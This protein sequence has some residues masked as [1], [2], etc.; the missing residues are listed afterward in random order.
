MSISD[1]TLELYR[2]GE[3]S[4]LERAAVEAELTSEDRRRLA[5][6][7]TSDGEIL[8]LY[9]PRVVAI[10]I[11]RKRRENMRK[12]VAPALGGLT[13]V[14]AALAV[15]V[16]VGQLPQTEVPSTDV[17]RIL[18]QDV[19]GVRTKSQPG[20]TI[21]HNAADD[22]VSILPES[23]PV[24]EGDV[25]QLALNPG[26]DTRAVA[27]SI[28]GSGV[29]TLH[30][31]HNSMQAGAVDPGQNNVLD[32]A[33]RLDDAPDFER[34]F[35]VTGSDDFGVQEV[36]LAAKVLAQEPGSALDGQLALPESLHVYEHLLIKVS[37]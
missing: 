3:L 5:D 37:Q 15:F 8:A 4:A 22:E 10:D 9:P 16:V 6:L 17:A 30:F 20:L 19:D 2:M 31:P 11:E 18:V 23:A 12:A 26:P 33:Y 1:Y 7:A 34:F 21:K 13:L 24:H 36:L 29:V 32:E 27:F 28:D 35:L 25:L 14:G